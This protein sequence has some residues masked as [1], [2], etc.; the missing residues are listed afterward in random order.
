METATER[1]ELEARP[2]RRRLDPAV[3][4]F[5]TPEDVEPLEGTVK[6]RLRGYRE[7]LRAFAVS[8]DGFALGPAPRG[9]SR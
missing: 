5:Q 3:L 4:Q 7:R 6:D 8:A 9:V 1:L 2:L